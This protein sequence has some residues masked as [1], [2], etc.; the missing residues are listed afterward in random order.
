MPSPSDCRFAESH[1]W[2]QPQGDLVALGLSRF[3]VDELTDVTFV[4]LPEA[5]ATFNAG[6][7]IGEVESVKTT[8]D[9]YTGI[10]GE[11]A[12]VN[13]KAVGD[14]SLLNSDP[15]GDGWLVK[16]KP[17]DAAQLEALMSAEEYDAKYPTA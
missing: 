15:F 2:H 4:D 6:D 12:E 10:G 3:A 7:S 17:T 8:S 13:D 5:G 9:I 14:P 11:I 16:I 1:E